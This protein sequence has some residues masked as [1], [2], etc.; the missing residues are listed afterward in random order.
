MGDVKGRDAVV[1]ISDD[2]VTYQTLTGLKDHSWSVD[3]EPIDVTDNDSGGWR[4]F[5]GGLSGATFS[6]TI[7]YDEADAAQDLIRAA[8]ESPGAKLYAKYRPRGTG[9]GYREILFEAFI[10][11]VEDSGAV[12]GSVEMSVELQN[13]G[14]PTF[15]NQT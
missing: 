12:D 9:T 15:Q 14:Q 4:E 8:N 5:L 3:G 10:S 7:N 1:L 6:M 2:D 11:S 13:S